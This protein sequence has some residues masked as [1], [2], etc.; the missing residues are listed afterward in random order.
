[1]LRYEECKHCSVQWRERPATWPSAPSWA[2][3][4]SS[5]STLSRRE[6]AAAP[7][8]PD[9]AVGPIRPGPAVVPVRP[10]PAVAPVR[11]GPAGAPVRPDPAVATL[12]EKRHRR[13]IGGLAGLDLPPHPASSSDVG[14]SRRPTALPTTERDK[15]SS[16]LLDAK[17]L[18]CWTGQARV[19]VHPYRCYLADLEITT[20]GMPS[21][22]PG[23]RSETEGRRA[24]PTRRRSPLPVGLAAPSAARPFRNTTAP[25]ITWS[26]TTR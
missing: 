12:P 25:A 10:D 8:R 7:I 26:T 16:L 1:M 13:R 14:K 22:I 5:T 20:G 6:A 15:V 18:G 11:T 19:L 23:R 3:S 9:P 4:R 2:P 21:P 17:H 24:S